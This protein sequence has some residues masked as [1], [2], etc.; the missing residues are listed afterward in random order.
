ML[1]E[2]RP[3]AAL[4]LF[5][6]LLIGT[7]HASEPM[8]I[9][10]FTSADFPI[11]DQDDRAAQ[12]VTVSVYI[13][14]GLEHFE[15]ALSQNLSSDPE[16]AKIEAL[17]RIGALDAAGMAGAKHAA[18]GLVKGKQYDLDRYPAIVLNGVAVV[19]GVTDLASVVQRYD[20]WRNGTAQ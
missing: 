7:A 8:L 19:Y 2:F 14:D 20:V 10:V 17:Q 15:S 4:M 6:L 3:L 16:A 12:E 11:S 18:M 5:N 13:V 9:E 1:A